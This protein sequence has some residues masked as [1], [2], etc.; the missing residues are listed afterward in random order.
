VGVAGWEDRAA[1]VL[2]RFLIGY[3]EADLKFRRV[4]RGFQV[5]R[6]YGGVE[7]PVGE[8]WIGEVAYFKVSE[9]ELRRRVEEAR[10][11]APDLSGIKKIRQTLPWFATDV[12]FLRKWI[13]AGTAHLWQAAWYVALFGEPES[14]SGGASVTEEGIKPH[15]TMRWRREDLDRIIAAES[16]E[17]M[18][19]LGRT[20]KSWR[21][22][23]D[24]IDWSWVVERVEE[25]VNKLKP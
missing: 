5:F 25:L 23:V 20:V 11:T 21:K 6:V 16:D 15:V 7:A 19:L 22:L 9:E 2:L 4:V 3:G 17:L 8:L 1:S 18:P 10:R 24:A 13:E 12:S 14:K